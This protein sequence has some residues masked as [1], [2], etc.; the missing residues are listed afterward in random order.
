M[1]KGKSRCAPIPTFGRLR[2]LSLEQIHKLKKELAE[3]L[4]RKRSAVLLVMY[5]PHEPITAI[6]S[7]D[8]PEI[9][10]ILREIGKVQKLDLLIN[11]RGGNLE[12]AY[13]I[14]TCCR[15]CCDKFSVIIPRD[16]Y[17]A[18]TLIALGANE[19]IMGPLGALGPLDPMIRHPNL[20][21][22]PGMAI[23][24]S[25]EVLNGEL[26]ESRS[27]IS[28]KGKYIV[29]PMANQIDPLLFSTVSDLVKAAIPYALDLL[30]KAGK[31]EDEAKKLIN[32][33]IEGYPTHGIGINRENAKKL[34]FNVVDVAPEIH[35]CAFDILKCYQVICEKEIEVGR[36]PKLIVEYFIPK[37][38][39]ENSQHRH[40]KKTKAH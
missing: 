23:R 40:S 33:L 10:D 5:Y 26:K 35:E 37:S 31:R 18:A 12:A 29:L 28:N 6:R 14:A 19:I 30:S 22:I 16:A 38:K 3:G 15:E 27:G 13:Q 17:S 9:L 34:G 11:S 4:A 2:S 8:S 39:S 7:R 24:R 1:G 36:K 32:I 20:G 25:L 21:W